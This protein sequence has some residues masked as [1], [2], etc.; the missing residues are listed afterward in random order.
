M[1]VFVFVLLPRHFLCSSAFLWLC[2]V[3]I[4]HQ[5]SALCSSLTAL[6]IRSD[7]FLQLLFLLSP[8]SFEGEAVVALVVQSRSV[9]R[10][11]A[12]ALLSQEH[13]ILFTLRLDYAAILRQTFSL[14]KCVSSMKRGFN[15][16]G[17]IYRADLRRY[18][19]QTSLLSHSNR[20]CTVITD[21]DLAVTQTA[22]SAVR[23]Y[24]LLFFP[25]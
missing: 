17:D 13:C 6:T 2:Q 25:S 23:T 9:L 4:P 22:R 21:G 3:L 10:V 5:S 20:A 24:S 11:Q 1:R 19:D 16:T 8:S 14:T 18:G 15:V 12:V 7:L